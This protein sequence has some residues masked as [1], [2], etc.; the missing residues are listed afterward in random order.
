MLRRTLGAAKCEGESVS[1][2]SVG[3]RGLGGPGPFAPMISPR[4]YQSADCNSS[5]PTHR[6]RKRGSADFARSR[7]G[8]YQ[9]ANTSDKPVTLTVA[10]P[11]P[12]IDLSEGDN[13]ALPSTDPVNFVDFETKIDGDSGQVPDGSACDVGDRD[14]SALLDQFKLP[15]LPIGKS[16][17]HIADLPEATRVKLADEGLL[18]PAGTNEKGRQQYAAAWVAKTS[19]VRQQ[20][21][22]PDRK[23]L[24]EHQYRPSVGTSSDTILRWVLRNNKSLSPEVNGIESNTA[25]LMLFWRIWT[26]APEKVSLMLR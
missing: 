2:R 16:E 7:P 23:V 20:T 19:A 8:R 26:S 18:M 13:V 15:L 5:E 10:F 1:I 9:F 17:I 22:P 4:S 12:D 24:V 3:A 6:D 11:L 21:F 14:V 25:L